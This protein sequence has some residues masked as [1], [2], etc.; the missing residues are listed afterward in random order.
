MI[1]TAFFTR[2]IQAALGSRKR[3]RDQAPEE[4]SIELVG[5]IHTSPSHA[6]LNP[7]PNAP[8]RPATVLGGLTAPPSPQ[9]NTPEAS[10]PTTPVDSEDEGSQESYRPSITS[11]LAPRVRLWAAR[12]S[13]NF[14]TI[15]YASILLA[16]LPV[17]YVTGYAMPAQLGA[18]VLIYLASLYIPMRHRAY[19]HPLI[20]SSG[21]SILAIWSLAAIRGTPCRRRSA[22]SRPA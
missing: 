7:P 11:V 6:A 16:G 17:Y 13:G 19:L 21:S 4:T 20:V 22:S 14:N 18:C 5:V 1:F 2:G 12:I 3:R 10:S 15:I 8:T 9:L